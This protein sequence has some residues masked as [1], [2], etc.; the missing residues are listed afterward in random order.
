VRLVLG[1]FV[2]YVDGREIIARDGQTILEASLEAGV[3]IPH[4]CYQENLHPAGSCR[5]CMVEIEGRE[6]IYAACTT[7]P[8][9]GMKVTVHGE[10]ADKVRNL[11]MA[12][13]FSVHPEECVGWPTT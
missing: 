3:Y 10:K 8:D 11:S 12:L 1:D 4:I 9:Q 13:L 7:K 5:L 2:F 6:G